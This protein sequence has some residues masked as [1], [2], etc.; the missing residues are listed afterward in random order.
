MKFLH[1]R[2]LDASLLLKLVNTILG[3]KGNSFS[4]F[5]CFLSV[6]STFALQLERW[7]D[8]TEQPH[9]KQ[10][11]ELWACYSFSH[12]KPFFTPITCGWR[13][14]FSKEKCTLEMMSPCFNNMKYLIFPMLLGLCNPIYLPLV[15]FK[16]PR[17]FNIEMIC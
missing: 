10:K 14:Q 2:N 17:G 3:I 7:L 9:H 15:Q 16:F 11:A 12:S 8:K 5:P 13:L 4:E 1:F 6:P